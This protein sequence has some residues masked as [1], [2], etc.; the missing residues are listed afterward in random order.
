MG[1]RGWTVVWVLGGLMTGWTPDLEGQ[2]RDVRGDR[3]GE[4]SVWLGVDALA[5]DPQ[6]PFGDV[7]DAAW[8]LGLELH[9]PVAAEGALALRLDGGFLNYGIE[10][11]DV[12][13]GPPI[14]CRID[15]DLTTS[16]NIA[17]FGV[18][19]ELVAP[20]GAIR[21]YVNAA[22][23]FSYFFTHSSLDGDD[24]D[25]FA[26]TTNFDDLVGQTRFGGGF[27]TRLGRT[28]LLDLGAQYHRNGVVDYLREGD[29]VD[30]PDGSITLHARR[31]DA[32]LIVYRVGLTFGIG[33]GDDRG[34]RRH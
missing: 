5:A 11:T 6:G 22:A 20:R 9:V 27:R 31:S 19:P 17:W 10:R 34:R 8:G 24:A 14:G 32:N 26:G 3:R 23:G 16:N 1:A 28:V 21:P 29:I 13:F 15:V 4:P 7:V 18:G 25:S 33:G 12:C 30:H 2:R